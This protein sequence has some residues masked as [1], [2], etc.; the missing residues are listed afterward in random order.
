[1]NQATNELPGKR[2]VREM[3][4]LSFDD[5]RAEGEAGRHQRPKVTSDLGHFTLGIPSGDNRL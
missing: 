5:E 2:N 4:L 3:K 1:M